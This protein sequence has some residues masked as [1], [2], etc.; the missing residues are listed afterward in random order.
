MKN[1]LIIVNPKAGKGGQ[2]DFV[3]KVKTYAKSN[4]LKLQLYWTNGR[5]DRE[6]VQQILRKENFE[7]FYTAGGDGTFRQFADLSE[8]DQIPMGIIPLGTSN[9]M[10]TD[11]GTDADP[12]KAFQN[13]VESGEQLKVDQLQLNSKLPLYHIGDIG[14]NA[15]LIDSFENSDD[16]GYLSYSKHLINR[17]QNKKAF[18][19]QIETEEQTYRGSAYMIAICNARHFGSGIPLNQLSHPADGKFELVIFQELHL[20]MI[21]KSGISSLWEGLLSKDSGERQVIQSKKA[22]I[23]IRPSTLFQIDGE[24]QSSLKKLEISVQEKNLKLICQADCPYLKH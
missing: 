7:A 5:N 16:S 19:Y 2:L 13:L 20:K 24:V 6:Q 18:D 8:Q 22:K 10:A 9:G 17:L 3:E 4:Q 15:K 14:A 23:K 11:L 12:F 1:L 21:L